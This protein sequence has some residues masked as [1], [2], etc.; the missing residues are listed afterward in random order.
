LILRVTS[1]EQ[2]NRL[3]SGWIELGREQI[4][5]ATKGPRQAGE[6]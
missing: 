6:I 5:T 2:P 3:A 4:R 1:G